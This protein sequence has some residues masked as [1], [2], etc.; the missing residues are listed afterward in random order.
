MT[1]NNKPSLWR[2]L[3]PKWE[4]VESFIIGRHAAPFNKHLDVVATIERNSNGK[5]R[6]TMECPFLPHVYPKYPTASYLRALR[7]AK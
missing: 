3:F 7:D 1:A 6:G 2:R 4:V 5:E